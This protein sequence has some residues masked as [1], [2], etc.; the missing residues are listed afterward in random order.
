M[1]K[2]TK[3]YSVEFLSDNIKLGI[4]VIDR[5][6]AVIFIIDKNGNILKKDF[7]REHTPKKFHTSRASFK[8]LS[9]KKDLNYIEGELKGHL[10]RSADLVFNFYKKN[11]FDILI[12]GGRKEILSKINPKIHDYLQQIIF[13]EF[14]ADPDEGTN[15][16]IKKALNA[17]KKEIN[18]RE[19]QGLKDSL[20][21]HHSQTNN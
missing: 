4:F 5:E 9:E 21:H 16:I 2:E 15:D 19:E 6:G 10:K 18:K 11:K 7:L 14:L 1:N 3:V 8:G 20:S 17:Y 12:L 13:T